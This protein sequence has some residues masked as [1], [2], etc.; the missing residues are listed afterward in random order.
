MGGVLLLTTLAALML[1]W[2]L[3]PLL[4]ALSWTLELRPLPWLV[5]LLLGWLLAG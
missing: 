4:A 1:L 2:L 3:Q 5:L